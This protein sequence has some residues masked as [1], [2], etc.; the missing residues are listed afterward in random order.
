VHTDFVCYHVFLVGAP[1]CKFIDD[2]PGIS[3]EP[4]EL[5]GPQK[6]L[7]NVLIPCLHEYLQN[8]STSENADEDLDEEQKAS[9]SFFSII[10]LTHKKNL[11][12]RGN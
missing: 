5:S 11:W 8:Y 9:V 3:A 1:F 4:E 2:E 10:F 6:V 7:Q 12:K